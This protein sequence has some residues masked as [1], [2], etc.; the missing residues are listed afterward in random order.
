MNIQLYTD[1]SYGNGKTFGGVYL[2]TDNGKEYMFKVKTSIQ[3]MHDMN[4]VG[5]E[6]LGAMAGLALALTL[7]KKSGDKVNFIDLCY[8]YEGIGHWL[9]K[10]WRATKYATRY[11]LGYM[12]KVFEIAS[13]Y[14]CDIS[15]RWTKSHSGVYGNEM[16][17]KVASYKQEYDKYII[18]NSYE[19]IDSLLSNVT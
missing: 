11:F 16:A 10:E 5:G 7:V 2:V 13:K 1:G 18:I 6:I 8:D 4:N 14:G 9:D 17:D 19:D 12:H 15:Y 3:D